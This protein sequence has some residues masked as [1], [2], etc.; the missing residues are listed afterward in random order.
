ME[1]NADTF[2]AFACHFDDIKTTQ[3][4]FDEIQM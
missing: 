4:I 2:V 3:T 1:R